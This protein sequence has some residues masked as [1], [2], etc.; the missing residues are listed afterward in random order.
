MMIQKMKMNMQMKIITMMG[1]I[2]NKRERESHIQGQ[3]D[4]QIKNDENDDKKKKK[5]MMMMGMT[6]KKRTMMMLITMTIR[7]ILVVLFVL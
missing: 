2:Q 5:V 4:R 1:T 3:G 7:M 6:T